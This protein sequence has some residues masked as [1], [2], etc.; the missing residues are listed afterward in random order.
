M[1]ADEFGRAERAFARIIAAAYVADHPEAIG[2]KEAGE[3]IMG[4]YLQTHGREN[5]GPGYEDLKAG[6]AHAENE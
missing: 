4:E 3:P 2:V 1:A 6:G 5:S